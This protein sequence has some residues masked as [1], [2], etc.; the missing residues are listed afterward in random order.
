M[1]NVGIAFLDIT[2]PHV[3][4]RADILREMPGVALRSLW[5]PADK[6]GAATFS[7]RYGIPVADSAEAILKDRQVDAVIVEAYTHQMADITVRALAA[8]KAVLLEKPAANNPENMRL[9]VEAARKAKALVQIGYMM[10]QGSMVDFAREVL[11]KKL[12]GRVTM[13]RF[14]VS[15][16]APDATTAWF[17]LEQDIGGV[18]FED[19][20]HMID[21]VLH[22]MG[23][24]RRVSAFVPKFE[25]LKRKHRHMYEDA[26]VLNL[27]WGGSVGTL[28]LAGWEANEWIE[29]WE[30]EF[31]GTEGTLQVG[32]LPAVS[33]LFLREA[34]GGY[35]KGW[36]VHQE[37]QFNVSWLDTKAKHVWHAVQNR[38]FFARE[39]ELFVEAVRGKKK[40]AGVTAE[41]A[42]AVMEV[43]QA[44][45]QSS[46]SG[47]FVD[48]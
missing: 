13:A 30:M 38:A 39:A 9:I 3:W 2:H 19:G 17:N 11:S 15:V 27:D 37:T 42:L 47:A 48:L 32:L 1:K 6:A 10:R 12:L 20:C 5:E 21:I 24:P 29:T 46:R 16:P 36:N 44:A 33:R 4:T 8:G 35:R 26:A 14:H 22:L 43:V 7:E 45:Y 25:D 34:R 23:R 40:S 41:D 18:L 28:S 31:F